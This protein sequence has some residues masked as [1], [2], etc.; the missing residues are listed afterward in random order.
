MSILKGPLSRIDSSTPETWVA[1]VI[2]VSFVF[3]LFATVC[4]IAQLLTLKFWSSVSVRTENRADA[5]TAEACAARLGFQ[6]DRPGWRK[7]LQISWTRLERKTPARIFYFA[8]A[9]RLARQI[10]ADQFGAMARRRGLIERS[11]RIPKKFVRLISKKSMALLFSLAVVYDQER[12]GRI[13]GDV[14]VITAQIPPI[15]EQRTWIPVLVLAAGVFT[16]ARNGNLIDRVRARDE[17]AKDTNRLLTELI[18]PLSELDAALANVHGHISRYR[19]AYFDATCGSLTPGR[20]WSPTSGF[21]PAPRPAIFVHSK[22]ELKELLEGSEFQRLESALKVVASHLNTIRDKGLSSVALR[23]LTPVWEELYECGIRYDLYH[24]SGHLSIGIEN[25]TMS[26]GWVRSRSAGG[27]SGCV[28]LSDDEA[29][30]DIYLT[31]EAYRFDDLILE[32]RLAYH[33]LQRIRAFLIRRLH[34]TP[35]TKAASM[36]GQK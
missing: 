30:L 7:G 25:S 26:L 23:I 20:S 22:T 27:E 3:I 24:S 36:V 5:S 33:G 34:G 21:R 1:I 32:S 10:P 11:S 28:Q 12:P 6:L 17:A 13:L 14:Q 18:A 15:A 29:E 35:L 16:Y 31:R 19:Y 2:K 9:R 8:M 4:A